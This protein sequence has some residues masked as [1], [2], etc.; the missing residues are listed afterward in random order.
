MYRKMLIFY[1]VLMMVIVGTVSAQSIVPAP[2]DDAINPNINI[3]W[4]PPVYILRGSAPIYGTANIDRMVNYFLEFR[5]LYETAPD[6]SQTLAN[7][8]TP[9][10]PITLPSAVSVTEA[11]LGNW[12][13]LTTPDG[14]YELRLTVNVSGQRSQNFVVSPIRIENNPSDGVL[15]W[16]REYFNIAPQPAP[17][18]APVVMTPIPTNPPARPTLE[19][20]PT[21][22][23]SPRVTAGRLDVNVRT[24]TST[25][26]SAIASLPA[27]ESARVI[28]LANDGSGWYYIYHAGVQGWV[29]GH[30]VTPT[31]DFSAVPRIAPPPPPAT[32]TPTAVP[33][34][35]NLTGSLP[36]LSANPPVCN[37]PFS[38]QVNI[39]N[40]GTGNTSA[41][42]NVIVEDVHVGTG[43]VQ[44]SF[45]S[46]VPVLSPGQNYV[47]AGNLTVS[48]YYGESHLIRVRIDPDNAIVETN[49]MDNILQVSYTLAQGSC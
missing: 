35:A 42:V 7:A 3:A 37:T 17:T 31:G 16:L 12:N 33:A 8:D 25:L 44:T 23:I 21:I 48:T 39:T 22:D 9:W 20:I 32:P 26:F 43:S 5:P 10:F 38:V 34:V 40:N 18:N 2:D 19:P 15:A 27:G 4:P 29:A 41:P 11:L 13:T 6:G 30:V 24:G 46:V 47:V 36:A 28:G 14:L 45:N 49:K 1:T